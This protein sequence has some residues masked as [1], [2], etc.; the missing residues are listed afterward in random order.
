LRTVF[1]SADVGFEWN[2]RSEGDPEQPALLWEADPQLFAERYPDSGIKGSYG[3][4][5][6]PPCLDYW[7]YVDPE[8]ETAR[9]S[10]EGFPEPD[11]DLALTGDG[12]LD[13]AMLAAVFASILR[14]EGPESDAPGR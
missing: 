9:L 13:G 4:Q 1:A 11:R 10:L 6:P 3:D 8:T 5:W 7:V 12:A 2:S 14:L